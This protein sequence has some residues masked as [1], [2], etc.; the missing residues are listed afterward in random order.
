MKDSVHWIKGIFTVL[1][2]GL[3]VLFFVGQVVLPS[4]QPE[5]GAVCE[6][7][8]Y[9]S[10][11]ESDDGNKAV[12]IF[13]LPDVIPDG[14]NAFYIR[15]R[16]MTVY[17]GG[18]VRREYHTADRVV[19]TKTAE[20]WIDVP[21]SSA[22][23]G[24]TIE[25]DMIT[26]GGIIYTSYLCNRFGFWKVMIRNYGG[27][28]LVALFAFFL[29]IM[30]II[31][32]I[33]L[34]IRYR[35]AVP[36]M[37][38]GFGVCLASTWVMV[39]SMFRQFVFPS[40]SLAG[41]LPF[42]VIMLIPGPFLFY[43]NANQ[44]GRYKKFYLV[45]LLINLVDIVFC[46]GVHI[47]KIKDISSVFN[48]IAVTCFISIITIAVTTILDVKKGLTKNYRFA[49]IG[50]MCAV[51]SGAVQIVMYF[52]RSGVFSGVVLALGLTL[53]LIFSIVDAVRDFRRLSVEKTEAVSSNKAKD[54]FL[55]NMSHE[56]RTPINAILG[57]DEMIY[58]ESTEDKI[59]EYSLDVRN[60]GRN[61][62]DI[63]ND[64]LDFS[65]IESGKLDIVPIEYDLRSMIHDIAVM[66]RLRAA[67]KGL[68]FHMEI[69][70]NLPTLLEG[71]VIRVRQVIVNLLT[72]AVK[73][74]EEGGFTWRLRGRKIRSDELDKNG[75]ERANSDNEYLLS[76]EVEDTGIGMKPED[77]E[78]LFDRYSRMDREKNY[79][80]EGTGL[81]MA[82]TSQLLGLM[83]TKLDV[84]SE[85]GIGSIFSF[86]LVQ[87]VVDS[88]PIGDVTELSSAD[89]MDEEEQTGL[90]IGD[91]KILVVDDQEMNRR[92]FKSLLKSSGAEIDEA[93]SGQ[94]CLDMTAE[95]EYDMVFLDH[96]MP[97][98]D[99]METLRHLKEDGTV[100]GTPTYVSL[101]ANAVS[102]AEEKYREA[103]F[104]DYLTKPILPDRLEDIIRKWNP[105]AVANGAE[106][107]GRM[108]DGVA[109]VLVDE[110]NANNDNAE[111]SNEKNINQNNDQ[112]KLEEL[113]AQ[114]EAVPEI[115]ID[116][117][118][119]FYGGFEEMV[120]S[121][122]DF[123][124]IGRDEEVTLEDMAAD[125]EDVYALASSED[126]LPESVVAALDKLRT[127]VHAMKTMAKYVG[128]VTLAGVAQFLEDKARAQDA[129]A[130]LELTPYFLDEWA[131]YGEIFDD[132]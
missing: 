35:R 94:M 19:G 52:N 127:Q 92:V 10:L 107:K 101:T 55:A 1:A 54:V 13:R 132:L 38:L 23:A 2:L 27:E 118:M 40:I 67:D 25:A 72:N 47:L 21:L 123:K 108:K 70:P 81:G 68:E 28:I 61:L 75:G 56:I 98:M 26:E 59:K 42:V 3:F 89:Y 121:I 77:L 30:T 22:D 103:G 104:D 14:A 80:V 112:K 83:G 95:K 78:T 31:V 11:T 116:Y 69:D 96:M 126:E 17:V 6:E 105:E 12:V 76:C 60:A 128:A 111:Q 36:L 15:G 71:D 9:E 33:I 102:G 85:Y 41:D 57:M 48:Y 86:D 87:K 32:C 50:M 114:L 45:T 110:G 119:R 34:R 97:E 90:Y 117:A 131:R 7:L 24:K 100:L 66:I 49:T 29:S 39:N 84:E 93:E 124:D 65:K 46:A 63:I 88:E 79:N 129:E 120:E 8:P 62:L 5:D 44:Q 109:D 99:G 16:N 115:D 113:R 74:T 20:V 73:Y 91:V 53:L 51:A 122:E 18:E 64:I 125:L 130:V 82:I 58:R 37:D 4:D 43:S 106:S